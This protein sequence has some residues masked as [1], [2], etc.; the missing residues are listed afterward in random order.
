MLDVSIM[1]ITSN[2]RPPSNRRRHTFFPEVLARAVESSNFRCVT[3][4]VPNTVPCPASDLN[5]Q[6]TDKVFPIPWE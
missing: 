3:P 4:V 1:Q 5:G 6:A 2:I